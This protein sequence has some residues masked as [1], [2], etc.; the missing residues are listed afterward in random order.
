MKIL[1]LKAFRLCL[2]NYKSLK[3]IKFRNFN[4][5]KLK[6]VQFSNVGFKNFI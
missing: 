5:F 1:I 4:S 2:F 6:I 3:L